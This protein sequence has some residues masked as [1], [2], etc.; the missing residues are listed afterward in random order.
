MGATVDIP[1][2]KKEKLVIISMRNGETVEI[3]AFN[4]NKF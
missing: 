2:C 3:G 1:K 4:V